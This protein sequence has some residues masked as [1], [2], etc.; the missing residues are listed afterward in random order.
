MKES[1]LNSKSYTFA[2]DSTY[3]CKK[4]RLQ[5]EYVMSG[6]LLRS[7]IS[8]GA[9]IGRANMQNLPDFIHKLSISLKACNETQYWLKLLFDSNYI[10]PN[11]FQCLYTD[12]AQIHEL[13]SG[14]ILTTKNKMKES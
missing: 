14:S 2:L 3:L 7:A 5:N 4:L 8:M 13:L 9:N 11:D 6:Q 12:S 10:E 1:L